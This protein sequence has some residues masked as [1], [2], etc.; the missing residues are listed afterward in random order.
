MDRKMSMG[1]LPSLDSQLLKSAPMAPSPPR[2]SSVGRKVDMLRLF[3]LSL[4]DVINMNRL[5]MQA[6][7]MSQGPSSEVRVGACVMTVSGNMYQGA[8]LE[9]G[10]AY[11]GS[12]SAEDCAL[13]KAQSE[14]QREV[15]AIA[16]HVKHLVP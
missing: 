9:S 8:T 2:T 7:Y 4:G 10:S 14:G 15:K 6:S 1:S 16:V 11:G 12:L 3:G 5:A 13:S